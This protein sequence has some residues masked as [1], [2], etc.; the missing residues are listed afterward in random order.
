MKQYKTLS[1]TVNGIVGSNIRE[2][3]DDMCTLANDLGIGVGSKINGE[4]LYAV[5]GM[6]SDALYGTYKA[7]INKP[8]ENE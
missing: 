1:I 5:P 4:F 3:C 8:G 6:P 2:I 7:L